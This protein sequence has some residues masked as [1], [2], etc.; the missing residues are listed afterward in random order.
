[1]G[2]LRESISFKAAPSGT[3]ETLSKEWEGRRDKVKP[4]SSPLLLEIMESFQI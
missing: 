2:V 4:Q 3:A 1:M